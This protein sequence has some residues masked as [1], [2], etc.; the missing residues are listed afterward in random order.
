[1][2]PHSNAAHAPAPAAA[3]GLAVC[4]ARLDAAAST[5]PWRCA[6]SER[7]TWVQPGSSDAPCAFGEGA[8]HDRSG[9]NLWTADETESGGPSNGCVAE[10]AVLT[11]QGASAITCVRLESARS[12]QHVTAAH[13]HTLALR[14]RWPLLEPIDSGSAPCS[15][16]GH[17]LSA[18]DTSRSQGDIVDGSP[19]QMQGDALRQM[20][21]L[22]DSLVGAAKT[23]HMVSEMSCEYP[24]I[25]DAMS[26][27]RAYA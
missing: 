25:R 21:G 9:R 19:G 11:C 13:T 3:H 12:P 17:N 18:N 26:A 23:Q 7:H 10:D 1:M 27:H 14:Q 6:R 24:C 15:A 22:A 5:P 2:L 4:P 8:V 20:S 16:R